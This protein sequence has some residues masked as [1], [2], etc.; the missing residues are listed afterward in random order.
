VWEKA[1]EGE[2]YRVQYS[3]TN[4][5]HVDIFPFYPKDGNMTK[6]DWMKTHRQDMPFPEKYLLPMEKLSF[7]GQ[8]VNVPNNHREFLDLKFGKGVIENPRYPNDK[9]VL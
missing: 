6:D 2:F 7:V 1:T 4:H 8:Q 9:P 3:A 5:L